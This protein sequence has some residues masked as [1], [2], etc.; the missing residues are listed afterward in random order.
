ML[1]SRLRQRRT[2]RRVL[3]AIP[4]AVA[5]GSLA[6]K[7][8]AAGAAGLRAPLT[9]AGPSGWGAAGAAT[10]VYFPE[11]GHHLQLGFLEHWRRH[12]GPGRLGFPLTEERWDGGAGTMVQ[13]FQHA[14]LEWR[15]G[16]P[17]ITG[18]VREVFPAPQGEGA[19]APVPPVPRVAGT[20]DWSAALAPPIPTIGLRPG[21]VRPGQTFLVEIDVDDGAAPLTVSA[22]RV[23]PGPETPAVLMLRPFPTAE[24]RF[25]ALAAAAMDEP[26][27]Q[28]AVTVTAGNG[29]GLESPPGATA[30]RVGEGGFPL[31]R[32]PVPAQVIPLLDPQVGTQERLTLA[33]V[34]AES[35]PQPLWRGQFFSPVPG[36]LVTAHGARRAYIDPD[37]R[38][39]ATG[40]HG[41]V[42]LA[43]PSGAAIVAPA[44]GVV[45]FAGA[46]SIR[47]NVVVLDHGA[48]VHSV[49]AHASNLAVAAG[50]AVARGQLL[51]RVGST[52]LSTGPHL[53]WEVR[54]AGVAV[55]PLEW[56][57]RPELGLL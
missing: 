14:R 41:G 19:R 5:L 10:S 35:A 8:G 38:T 24:T 36:P 18:P 52:G 6:S 7:G 22:G 12:Q 34:M 3:A 39:V 37:G 54:V 9:I 55:D 53:H 1:T 33:A 4:P 31:Q 49:Y 27:G 50:Q 20:P 25:V 11:T 21:T 45:A 13:D 16:L 30:L 29:L 26:P 51:G 42:D 32:L 2:R 15:P 43:A 46:W 57:Q 40:Q 17:G 44:A 56:T 47:G 23:S 48:G 28:W